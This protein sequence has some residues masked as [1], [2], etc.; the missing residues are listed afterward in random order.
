[1]K[2][3]D[4]DHNRQQ[5]DQY[6]EFHVVHDGRR[7]VQ[8][9]TGELLLYTRSRDPEGRG[10]RGK[11]GFTIFT[12][13]DGPHFLREGK[14]LHDPVTGEKI[15]VS[16]VP[17]GDV[18]LYDESSRRVVSL[19]RPL[20]VRDESLRW[21]HPVPSRFLNCGATCYFAGE[22]R[23]PVVIGEISYSQPRKLTPEEKLELKE[24]TLALKAMVRMGVVS[25]TSSHKWQQPAEAVELLGKKPSEIDPSVAARL[26]HRGLTV[27]R[28]H[29]EVPYLEVRG[30]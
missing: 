17:D 12:M 8:F 18:L 26:V 14:K 10:H 24:T 15:K 28:V 27:G 23:L 13:K 29:K 20:Y 25:G 11:F 1:M 16:W 4:F 2:L 19:E 6:K 30:E 5:W 3:P 22:N 9:A 21:K 7:V